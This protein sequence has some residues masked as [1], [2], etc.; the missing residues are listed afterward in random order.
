MI[1]FIIKRLTIK[2]EKTLLD[3]TKNNQIPIITLALDFGVKKMGMALG[4]NLTQDARPFDVLAMNN[5]QPDW[6][7]L[8]GIIETWKI[9]Q[10]LVG[11]PLNMD[12]TE[13]MITLRAKKFARRL[14]HRL[15]ERQ[16]KVPVFFY[17]E[18]LT[19]KEARMFAWEYGL[20]KQPTDPI[21]DVAACIL[22]NSY[23]HAPD[24]AVYVGSY[25]DQ[26]QKGK[27]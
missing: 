18:R 11:L 20:I 24:A 26:D 5:G 19:S 1:L 14:A 25:H 27:S 6:E 8:L 23:Y 2:R 22:L 9:G 10:I 12:G 3:S 4:N 16:L 7:N 17:D 21:D 15:G 13:S